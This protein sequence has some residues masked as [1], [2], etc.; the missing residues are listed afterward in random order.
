MVLTLQM[1]FRDGAAAAGWAISIATE[2]SM[3]LI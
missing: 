3:L 2:S 1:F